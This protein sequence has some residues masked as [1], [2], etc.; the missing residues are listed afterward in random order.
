MNIV[1][2]IILLFLGLGAVTGFVR[3]FFKQ[4]VMSV[5]TIL[6]V[7]LSFLLKNPLSMILY[8]NLPF[9]KM[10]GLTALN[11]LLYEALAFII[12]VAILSIAL[13]III[14]ITGIIETV[15][16]FTIILAL[17]SKLLGMVVGLIQSIVIIYVIL[18]VVSMPMFKVPYIDE[19]KYAKVILEKTPI[20]SS[21]TND[22]VNAFNEIKEFST[23][24]INI[25]NIKDTNRNIVEIML[26]NDIVTTD[27][28]ILL[29]EKGKIDIDNV[30]DL[31]TK[32]KKER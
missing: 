23:N 12:C 17:P 4:T 28:V 27:S 30:D 19:S 14:R 18:F 24:K 10:G 5:G 2:V 29:K 9:F 25:L 15:L 11:I 26:K 7:V 1:D 8:E 22:A 3:G 6:V 20:I 13:N 31:I 32:Y 16:K 21:I